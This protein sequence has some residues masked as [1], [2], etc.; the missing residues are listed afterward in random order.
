MKRRALLALG[1]LALLG[2]RSDAQQLGNPA[3]LSLRQGA[4]LL[5]IAQEW[6]RTQ[7]GVFLADVSSRPTAL[8]DPTKDADGNAALDRISVDLDRACVRRGHTLVLQRRFSAPDE[9]PG[10]EVAELQIMARE[11][12]RLI[13]PFAPP[14]Q[15]LEEIQAQNGFAKSLSAE[16]QQRMMSPEGP[17]LALPDAQRKLWLDIN[18]AQNY[19]S[20]ERELRR[21]SLLM[22]QWQNAKLDDTR[23]PRATPD[24]WFPLNDPKEGGRGGITISLARDTGVS[25]RP[26]PER[27]DLPPEELPARLKAGLS[28]PPGEYTLA[29]LAERLSASKVVVRF[30]SY[31]ANRKVVAFSHDGKLGEI[32]S[33]LCVLYGWTATPTR[34]GYQVGLPRFDPA[35]DAQDLHLKLQRMVPPAVRYQVRI[36]SQGEYGRS[37]HQWAAIIQEAEHLGGGRN[38][39]PFRSAASVPWARPEWQTTWRAIKF[40]I[41]QRPWGIG[42]LRRRGSITRSWACC[43]CPVRLVPASTPASALR[44]L[45]STD[46]QP[47]GVTRWARPCGFGPGSRRSPLND[48]GA[49]WRTAGPRYAI[50]SHPLR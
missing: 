15:G 35:K 7:G 10:V 49:V 1:L 27:T 30:P 9:D 17:P 8:K 14:F 45:R 13:S 39:N 41:G 32:L 21:L 19:G 47:G 18:Q 50:S 20:S 33:G 46:G 37:G 34:S 24:V 31:A 29:D 43:G 12:Y 25:P 38:G 2:A 11:M 16:Q 42:I 44:C 28:L 26:R 5:E 48:P 23:N 4:T 40:T 3:R 36:L 6:E 22:E